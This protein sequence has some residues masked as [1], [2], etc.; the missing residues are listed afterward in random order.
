MLAGWLLILS[1]V[2]VSILVHPEPT[3]FHGLEYVIITMAIGG[4]GVPPSEITPR[5]A[6]LSVFAG[7]V[8]YIIHTGIYMYFTIYKKK[9]K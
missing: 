5:R 1:V 2:A 6:L 9:D 3:T 7:V 8:L 4:Y